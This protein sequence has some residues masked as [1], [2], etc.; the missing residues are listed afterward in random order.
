VE[1]EVVLVLADVFGGLSG[2]FKQQQQ[3]QENM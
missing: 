2:D 3:Q 1:V